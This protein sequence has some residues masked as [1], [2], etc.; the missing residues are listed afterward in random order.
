M[1]AAHRETPVALWAARY[2]QG[3]PVLCMSAHAHLC[4]REPQ[5]VGALFDGD[6]RSLYTA[7]PGLLIIKQLTAERAC[8]GCAIR[9]LNQVRHWAATG[10]LGANGKARTH[11]CWSILPASPPQQAMVRATTVG[12][13]P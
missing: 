13:Q 8:V 5:S 12:C 4:S 10:C 9:A 7:R 3:Q 1:I 2:T 6:A 11:Q